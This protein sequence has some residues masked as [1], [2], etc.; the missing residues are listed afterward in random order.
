MSVWPVKVSW[1]QVL[2][3][4]NENKILPTSVSLIRTSLSYFKGFSTDCCIYFMKNSFTQIFLKWKKA[5][6]LKM[7]SCVVP[8]FCCSSSYHPFGPREP[9]RLWT[10]SNWTLMLVRGA[11]SDS[12]LTAHP[13]WRWCTLAG[14]GRGVQRRDRVGTRSTTKTAEFKGSCW[15]QRCSGTSAIISWW[16]ET[17]FLQELKNKLK[18]I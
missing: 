8:D 6:N 18:L 14:E 9:S 12:A 5:E 17:E 7:M 10:T 4:L 1:I 2:I 16:Q 3:L 15:L 13:S 11:R